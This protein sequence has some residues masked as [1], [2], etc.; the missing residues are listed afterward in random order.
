MIS[1]LNFISCII[2][3]FDIFLLVVEMLDKSKKDNNRTA[4]WCYLTLLGYH[5]ISISYYTIRPQLGKIGYRIF[6]LPSIF[7]A[8]NI[9]F[10]ICLLY[11]AIEVIVKKRLIFGDNRLINIL[12]ILTSYFFSLVYPPII[13]TWYTYKNWYWYW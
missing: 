1:I 2:L 11:I 6:D 5:A 10:S 4:R 7:L 8:T 3:S 9:L 13:L 12:I